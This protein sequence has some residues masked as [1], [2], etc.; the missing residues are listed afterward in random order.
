MNLSDRLGDLIFATL[1]LAVGIILTIAAFSYS[2]ESSILLRVLSIFIV[3]A[4]IFYLLKIFLIKYVPDNDES[5]EVKVLAPTIVFGAVIA[6]MA[7]MPVVGFLISFYLLIL[8]IPILISKKIKVL[9]FIYALGLAYFIFILF[10]GLLGVS[11][12]ESTLSL[13]QYFKIF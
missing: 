2:Y 4:S 9:Y 7:L 5:N 8:I 1:S 11:L 13:D 3:I 12:P 10:F 6:A